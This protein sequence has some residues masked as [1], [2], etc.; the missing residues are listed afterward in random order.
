MNTYTNSTHPEKKIDRTAGNEL[1]HNS[2]LMAIVLALVLFVAVAVYAAS[3]T[4]AVRQNNPAL[5]YSNALGM[6]YAQPWLAA[7]NKPVAPYSNAL[8]LQYAQPWL[9]AQKK[10]IVVTG[11]SMTAR[12]CHSSIEM[13]Y[14]CKYGNGRP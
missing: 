4:T 12:D 7:Q 11:N 13:L 2:A 6:Q 14:A 5:P 10:L 3:R 1:F 8:E 9:D